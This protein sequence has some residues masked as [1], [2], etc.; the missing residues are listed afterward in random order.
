[1]RIVVCL[2]QVPDTTDVKLDPV[3]HH[4]I[5]EGTV[6]IANPFDLHALTEAVRLKREIGAQVTVVSMG[7]PQAKT[8]LQKA[9]SLGAD[10]AILLTDRVFSGSD[11]LATSYIICQA[12][13]K[14]APDLILC[15]K[16]AI[17]GDTAQVGPGI[18]TRM[19]MPMLSYVS[20]IKEVDQEKKTI[21]VERK[22]EEG[23]ET[24]SSTFPLLL[25]IVSEINDVLYANLPDLMRSISFEP[26]VWTKD[27]LAIDL[28]SVGLKGSPTSVAKIFAPAM[29]GAGRVMSGTEENILEVSSEILKAVKT[30][31]MRCG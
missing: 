14:L 7:P 1:M 9:I 24:V 4:L 15:G 6:S 22:L 21:I 25:T 30:E 26:Q 5:R 3:T 27:D 8:A 28:N 16:Q 10:E 17:D 29:R 11:T 23:V 2:K 31:T 20:K 18:A 19:G 13:K 12:L